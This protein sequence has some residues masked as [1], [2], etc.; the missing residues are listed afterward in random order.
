MTEHVIRGYLG[1]SDLRVER[2]IELSVDLDV[3]VDSE[4]RIVAVETYG[5]L[6]DVAALVEV[7]RAARIPK[8]LKTKE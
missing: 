5:R 4:G 1:I 3:D 6:P 7:L 8:H 2:T